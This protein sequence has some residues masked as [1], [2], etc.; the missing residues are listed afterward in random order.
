MVNEDPNAK[1]IR[2]LRAEVE[3]LKQM[4]LGSAANPGQLQEKLNENENIMKE[5]SQTW[6]EKLKRSGQNK[7]QII[8]TTVAK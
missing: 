4:L 8:L 7:E 5:M 6:E 2:E 1:I 3:S